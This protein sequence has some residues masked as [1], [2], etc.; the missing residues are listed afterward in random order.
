VDL[1]DSLQHGP[2]LRILCDVSAPDS[3]W[4]PYIE[5]R[6]G[7]L[8]LLADL[9]GRVSD[10]LPSQ[11]ARPTCAAAWLQRGL[12]RPC[13]RLVQHDS[14]QIRARVGLGEL[15]HTYLLRRVLGNR[16]FQIALFV[17]TVQSARLCMEFQTWWSQREQTT[18]TDARMCLYCYPKVRDSLHDVRKAAEQK[19]SQHGLELMH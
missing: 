6:R 15:L 8:K 17:A 3:I 18:R 11:D 4:P 16:R 9:V 13:E 19:R 10:A 12:S 1:C 7:R 5:A 14:A 2:S